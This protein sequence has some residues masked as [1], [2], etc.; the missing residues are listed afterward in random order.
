[1]KL[2]DIHIRDPFILTDGDTYYMYGSR[3]K[4]CWNVGLGLDVYTSK[5]LTEWS[6]P[7]EVFS[8]PDNFWADRDFWA[9]EVH[10]YKGEYYMFVTFFSPTRTRGTQILKSESPLGPFQPHSDGPVTPNDWM[11]LDGT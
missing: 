6:E 9:P 11:C 4:E 8:K 10:K 3:G 1:M 7:I 2:N 5:D